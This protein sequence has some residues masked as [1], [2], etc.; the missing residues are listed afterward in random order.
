MNSLA[1]HGTNS[2]WLPR[3]YEKETKIWSC[4][5]KEHT[6]FNASIV[7]NK[8]LTQI[9]YQELFKS[10]NASL[11]VAEITASEAFGK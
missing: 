9:L 2:V 5:D 4:K 6:R 1:A 11:V 10:D 7:Q 8:E 3:K